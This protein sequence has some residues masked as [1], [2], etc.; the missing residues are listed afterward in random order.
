MIFD[1]YNLK[2]RAKTSNDY[3]NDPN[4]VY[5][6]H[7]NQNGK[8]YIAESDNFEG[9]T[10]SPETMLVKFTKVNPCT[11]GVY[12]FETDIDG[13]DVYS[14]D[15]IETIVGEDSPFREPFYALILFDRGGFFGDGVI[16]VEYDEFRHCRVIGNIVEN[17]ELLDLFGDDDWDEEE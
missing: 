4:W 16:R 9:I 14:G 7:I 6:H 12:S 3:R 1:Q 8:D 11:L 15:M 2:Y 13:V 10:L 5:G 17:P